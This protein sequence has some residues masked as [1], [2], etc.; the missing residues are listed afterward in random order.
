[1]LIYKKAKVSNLARYNVNIKYSVS[2]YC[3]N[4]VLI[5]IEN[6]SKNTYINSKYKM[7]R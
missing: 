2:I 7:L 5:N 3:Q 4:I 6:G 1:M